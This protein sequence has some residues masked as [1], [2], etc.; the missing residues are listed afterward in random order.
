[1]PTK[2][3]PKTSSSLQVT[4]E[5]SFSSHLLPPK[6]LEEYNAIIP[7]FAT[8]THQEFLKETQH[9]RNNNNWLVRGAVIFRFMGQSL[10]FG[11][12]VFVLWIAWD[13]GVKGHDWLAG[14]IAGIDL[15]GL[16]SVFLGVQY[17]GKVREENAQK[18]VEKEEKP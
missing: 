18:K 17:F 11:I 6:L 15:I 9:R 10:A 14:T 7:N 12:A 8:D 4:Q 16:V 3:E 2:T 5:V 1:M 13:L